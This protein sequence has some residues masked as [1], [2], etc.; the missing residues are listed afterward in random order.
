M[1]SKNNSEKNQITLL[2]DLVPFA[3]SSGFL[4]IKISV[5]DKYISKIGYGMDSDLPFL[6]LVLIFS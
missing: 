6:T 3:S 1:R 5:T 4:S 2:N